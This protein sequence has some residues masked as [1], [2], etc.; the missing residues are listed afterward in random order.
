MINPNQLGRSPF[1]ASASQWMLVGLRNVGPARI[2]DVRAFKWHNGRGFTLFT[3]T[4]T[5]S[6]GTVTGTVTVT[7]SDG[8][9]VAYHAFN[10]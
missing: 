10:S 6:G 3:V 8:G 9:G 1:P 4:L 5:P 2:L 7:P